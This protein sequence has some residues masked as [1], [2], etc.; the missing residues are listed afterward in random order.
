M[1]DPTIRIDNLTAE[2][3]IAGGRTLRQIVALMDRFDG[4]Q[5]I[6]DIPRVNEHR[7]SVYTNRSHF[8]TPS[9]GDLQWTMQHLA[10]GDALRYRPGASV[11]GGWTV[12]DLYLAYDFQPRGRQP[13]FG[14]LITS[15]N[16]DDFLPRI[17]YA[18]VPK[19]DLTADIDS[20]EAALDAMDQRLSRI[21]T[22]VEMDLQMRV[23]CRCG[24]SAKIQAR[25][26]FASQPPDRPTSEV[27]ALLKC[28]ECGKADL[29]ERLALFGTGDTAAVLYSSNDRWAKR[30]RS[31]LDR[32]DA[33]YRTLGGD[34]ENPVYVADGVSISPDGRLSE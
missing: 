23:K 31:T 4:I 22:W 30:N 5:E 27:V 10:C 21:G 29:L 34:G 1:N 14:K 12:W 28:N 13:V 2:T 11:Q 19:R 15:A 9:K 16:L 6:V 25:S 33:F 26:T 20:A 3:V 7:R 18:I 24:H 8:Y 17:S 32:V